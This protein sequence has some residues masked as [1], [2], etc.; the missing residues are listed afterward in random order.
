MPRLIEQLEAKGF[1][2]WPTGGGCMC[3]L[4]HRNGVTDVITNRDGT[5]LPTKSDW[6][7][8]VYLGDWTDDNTGDPLSETNSE[9]S[10]E[11][12]LHYV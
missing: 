1:G 4:R 7:F 9:A 8:C 10:A 5:G 6:L 2:R 11:G 3:L 12:L